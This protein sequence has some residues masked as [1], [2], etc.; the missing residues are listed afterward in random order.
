[1]PLVTGQYDEKAFVALDRIVSEAA[2]HG[3]RLILTMT[4]NWF[5]PDGKY[6]VIEGLRGRGI[7]SVFCGGT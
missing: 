7:I 5:V 3:V 4:D 6:Q 2:N 1:M